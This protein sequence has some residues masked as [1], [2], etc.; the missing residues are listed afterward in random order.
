M[1]YMALSV[2]N[3]VLKLQTQRL[4][5]FLVPTSHITEDLIFHQKVAVLSQNS[6][7]PPNLYLA[8]VPDLRQ[9]AMLWMAL[10]VWSSSPFVT[11]IACCRMALP[12]LS[13]V[14]YFLSAFHCHNSCL[15]GNGGDFSYFPRSF[16]SAVPFPNLKSS[17]ELCIVSS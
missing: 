10:A 12:H 1:T 14:F 5:A 4:A 11:C 8:S 7:P 15:Q 16:P 2:L 3:L 6:Y 13:T 9:P 17:T